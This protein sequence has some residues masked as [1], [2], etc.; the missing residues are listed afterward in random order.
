MLTQEEAEHLLALESIGPATSV[1]T[2]PAR[3]GLWSSLRVLRSDARS[4]SL[5]SMARQRELLPV[6]AALIVPLALLAAAVCALLFY[7]V[8]TYGFLQ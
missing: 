1:A 8:L 2:F 7:E 6:A 3:A 5:Y 4:M